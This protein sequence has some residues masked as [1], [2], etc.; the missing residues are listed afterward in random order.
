MEI[1]IFV[2]L[3]MI[4]IIAVI[5]TGLMRLLKQPLI[6]GYILTGVI[7]SPYFL[8]IIRSTDAISV[9]AQI[10]IALL[11]FIVGLNLNP[12]I[13][14][15]VGKVSLIT[16]VGQVI[17]TSVIGF[18]LGRLLGFSTIASIY[19][20]IALAFSSTVIITKLLSDKGDME[21]LYGRISIGF[22]IVQDLV[23]ILV[24]MV[25]ASI[26]TGLSFSTL[27]FGIILKGL[28]LLLLLFLVGAY[29]LPPICKAVAKSQEFLLLFSIGW[30]LALASLFYYMN[31]SIEIGAL[32]AGITLS[33]SAYR[34]EI[35]SKMKPLRDFFIILFFILLGSQMAFAN[36]SQYIIPI[37]VF[38]AF[39][40]IGNPLI[41]MA[42]MGLLGY[43]KRNS[44]LAGLTVAQISEFSLI[45]I[46][47]GV[48]VGHLTN[49]V[50]SIVTVIGLIT[51]AGSTYLIL[52][53]DKIY[54]LLS[55]YLGVFERKGKKVDE[56]RYHSD[57]DY[58]LILFGY[59]RIGYDILESFKKIKRRFLVVDYNPEVIIKLAKE[60][61][62]CK[63]GDADDSELLNELNFPRVKMVISTIPSL[64]TNLL[65]INKIRES[66]KRAI[67]IVVSH[68]IDEALKLYDEGATY[69]LMPH[70]LG[71]HHVS[72][73]IRDK[74]LS[75]SKFLKEKVAHIEHLK[76]RKELGHEHPQHHRHQGL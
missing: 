76:K 13:I 31:F 68:Q 24:L 12:R 61:F 22:L 9:F 44:F 36:I 51:I 53:A 28:G 29:I 56:H 34:Y 21:T 54:P 57:G 33:V 59:N 18:F 72:A 73:M 67:I 60:G 37:L 2:E 30:C 48:K 4:I 11:L 45:L 32:L 16:G 1:S 49:E 26:P 43:S 25:I 47:L 8:N 58:D 50:L 63:Y 69:V 75:V 42:L 71:G 5:V 27:V 55:R 64:D 39:I 74:K 15:D 23:A 14:K 6:I 41:V 66:N 46:I 3:S 7:L 65:L 20:A 52:Y 70:F 38:S 10:G 40:L 62:D 19:I 35:C 17:F